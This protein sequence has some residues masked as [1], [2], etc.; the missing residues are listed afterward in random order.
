M[1]P[2]RHGDW[3]RLKKRNDKCR[4][5]ITYACFACSGDPDTPARG[6]TK[7][8]SRFAGLDFLFSPLF[9]ASIERFLNKKPPRFHREG[10]CARDWILCLL[11]I[12]QL[13]RL[14][15]P[16][17]RMLNN[18]VLLDYEYV[19]ILKTN[20]IVN[21]FF[22][23]YFSPN[24]ISAYSSTQSQLFFEYFTPDVAF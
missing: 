20:C 15:D 3:E 4:D 8:S 10:F 21:K 11:T 2:G 12:N 1:C 19:L 24:K 6:R 23:S 13:R 17:F 7:T 9:N 16:F 18:S 22:F 14:W 5:W